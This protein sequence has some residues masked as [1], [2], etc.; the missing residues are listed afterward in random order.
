VRRALSS[1]DVVLVGHGH[2]LRVLAARWLGADPHLGAHLLL[3]PA[4]ISTLGE[5]HGVPAIASWNVAPPP[6]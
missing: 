6:L 5:A 2:C 1:G 4:T 3:D